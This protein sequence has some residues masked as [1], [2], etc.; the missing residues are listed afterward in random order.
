MA[1]FGADL[2]GENQLYPLLV[3]FRRVVMNPCFVNGYETGQKLI[4]IAVEQ[5]QASLR[6]CHTIAVNC[7]QIVLESLE[8]VQVN[9]NSVNYLLIIEIGG[10]ESSKDLSR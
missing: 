4:W 7:E 5:H 3:G 1:F 2:L 10:A 6:S 8:L 9:R